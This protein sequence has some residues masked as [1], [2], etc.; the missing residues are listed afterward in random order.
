[1]VEALERHPGV[2]VA[3]HY[4]GPAPRLAP[5]RAARVRR[6]P[7]GPRR[8]R[9]DR[10]RR[11]RLVRAGPRR[12][13]RARPGRPA[14]PDGRR[15]RGDVRPPAA[16]R[17]ARRARLGAGPA[18]GPR[19][20]R[21]RLDGPRRRPLPGGGDPR[22][23]PLGLLHD[24]RPGQGPDRLRH[25]AGPPLPDPVRRGR[26]R[27][28]LP[29]RPRDRGRRA[30]R[31]RWATTARSSAPGRRPG[32]TAGAGPL[33]R[34][35][36]RG[37]RRE[38]RLADDDARRRTGLVGH[39]PVGRVYLPTGSYAEMGEWA[40]PAD[41]GLAFGTALRRA[42]AEHRP[43]ARWLRGAI[44]RNFQVRYR[45]INDIHKQMLATSDLVDGDAAG[46]RP[47]RRA[48]TTSIAG[49]SN[50][51]YWHG[52]F[53]G[54][55]LPDLRVAALRRLIAAEDLAARRRRRRRA[56]RRDVD[57]D[58]RDE[59]VLAGAGPVR[60]RSSSRRA[61]GSRAGTCGPPAIRSRP[62]CAAGPRRTT[63]RSARTSRRGGGRARRPTDDRGRRAGL[64]PRHRPGQA[65]RPPRPP[66]LRRLRAALR[67]GPDP[68]A[69]HDA[70][71]RG[72]GRGRGARRPARRRLDARRPRRR[73]GR[74]S[75]GRV[76]PDRR[77]TG[78]GR[79]R[80]RRS[81]IGGGRLDPAP[82]RSSS[83]SS[84]A[85]TPAA[86][87]ST[88]SSASSG[89]RCSSAAATTR[90]PGTSVDG[91]ADRPR[92]DRARRPASARWSR[93][94]RPARRHGRDDD[95]P[96]GRRLDRADR[97]RLELGGAASSSSTR[98]ARR[99]SS[100]RS[101]SR[102]ASAGAPDRPAGDGRGERFG[103]RRPRTR[104][105]AGRADGRARRGR[106]RAAMTRGRLAVHAHFY[107]PSRL[108]PWTGRVPAEPSAAP[109]HDWNQRV[110]AECYRPNAERGTLADISW[111]LGP[112][113]AAW[114]ADGG[115][116]RPID[117]FVAD[118][119]AAIAQ[120]YHHTILPLAS[121]ADR[122]TEIA[123]G[124]RDFELRFG[125]RPAGHLAAR[126][127]GRSWRRSARRPRQGIALHD[128]R[129]VAGRRVG[130]R[131][132]PPLSGRARRR[133]RD[134]RR[135]LRRR[136]V[137]R[138]SRS[139]PRRPPTPT[140]SPASASRRGSAAA[141]R[142]SSAPLAVIATDG[143]LYGHH[144]QFR[145]LFLQRLAR[146][147]TRLRARSRVRRR[148]PRRR[149]RRGRRTGR[150]RRSGSSSGRRGAA[151]T[152]SPAGAAS[153]PTPTT[154]AGR[155][156]LRAALRAAGRRDRRASPRRAIRR[157]A[158]RRRP[159]TPR[160]TPMSTSSSARSRPRTSPPIAGR[161]RADAD[162]RARR[163]TCS[164]PSAGGSRCSRA[165][166][167]SGTTRSGPRR[168][169]SCGRRRGRS[170]SS[171]ARPGT[172][173][174]RRLVDDLAIFSVAV[175]RPRR[176]RDLPDG[177]RRR[178]PAGPPD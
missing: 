170:G 147:R 127:G 155:R 106:R 45:E 175:A 41:E 158:R 6:P 20:G 53:G 152:A 131:H 126:D 161:P 35:V 70:R 82:R 33:G 76:G 94:Q 159:A 1:M 134:R 114:M 85:A 24:R 92:R 163:S 5:G 50:D 151:I 43:E 153:A 157:A 55:Y 164:R 31:A 40:L 84:I 65:G 2:R 26:R 166:A 125:R 95:R 51:C 52:L 86:R 47:R 135:L 27:H 167:G 124:I 165:T 90:R 71:G 103:E 15:A 80:R 79:G 22:G 42:R 173:L 68:A 11:R 44:W 150:I 32:S 177:A 8:A 3:L 14:R 7:R 107:Q 142:R 144:Q 93:R 91:R 48:A 104:R 128:P 112:T 138:R 110:N 49:Q 18:D 66:P 4:T 136:P 109:F 23:R 78:P 67:A 115:S 119:A 37:P 9:P 69:G 59:V 156:P 99:C 146:R 12:P 56:V 25:R 178:R 60:R 73:P 111:N 172:R 120:P 143:E 16:R 122:R 101:G 10:D 129:P 83:R 72:V 171:T 28:R 160:G 30:A 46:R 113:L 64:D 154:A 34:A 81:A 57:L 61:A 116:G 141:R 54:I 29:P 62:S 108:D 89:R 58:G 168:A 149:R 169:R 117:R 87:R 96:P 162:R 140:A 133:P 105:A 132:P 97:D 39:R 123:W 130:H 77:R 102:R 148:D 36:L 17:V 98:A 38:R 19:L 139:S 100:S 88:R 121:A 118:S 137:D 176:R 75:A 63:R 21:L 74:R 13:A 174:E 145:D